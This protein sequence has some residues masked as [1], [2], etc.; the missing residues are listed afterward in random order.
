MQIP[1]NPPNEVERLQALN[2]YQILDSSPEPAFDEIAELAAFVMQVPVALVSLVDL[3][4]Q[5]FKARVGLQVSELP[6][7]V[8]F[9]G[10]VVGADTQLIVRDA[11]EDPRFVDNPLST[12][13]PQVRFYAGMPLRTSDGFVLGTLC[14]IDY[15]PRQPTDEQLGML[16]RLSR[17]VVHLLTN[18]RLRLQLADEN[19]QLREATGRLQSVFDIMDEGVVVQGITGEIVSNNIAATRILALSDDQLRGRTSI[20][21]RWQCVYEDGTPFPGAEHPSMQVLR[22]GARQT[23]VVMGVNIPNDAVRWISIN[24]TPSRVE[25]GAVHEVVTSFH[26]I[27]L[28]KAAAERLSQQQR[29]ATTGTLVAGIGHEINNPL[30]FVLGNLDLAIEE[31]RSLAGPSPSARLR[32][33]HELLH[34]ARVGADRIRRIVRGLRALSREEVALQPVDLAAVIETSLSMAQHEVRHKAAV[35]VSV[36]GLPSVLGDE[37]QLTQVLVNLLVNAGQAF[38]TAD[39]EKNLI[40]IHG[41]PTDASWLRL[42]VSDNGPGIP[43]DLTSRVFDPFFTTKAVSVGTGLGLA[44]SRGIVNGLGGHLLLQQPLLQQPLLQSPRE[45]GAV[46]HI[47]LRIADMDVEQAADA[48]APP[49]GLRGRVLVVDDDVSVL[50]TMRRA[51]A[52]EHDVVAMS[53]PREALALLRTEHSF[54]VIFCDLM[55]PHLTGQDLYELLRHERAQIVERIVFVTGGATSP[56]SRLFLDQLPNDVLAKPFTIAALLDTARRYLLRH[57]PGESL[58]AKPKPEAPTGLTQ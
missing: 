34:E 16:D 14:A 33:L 10:H 25:G 46:F 53:D 17:Q 18:R 22:T 51:L 44:V 9:C 4:R 15:R 47:D 5:W 32:E 7:D 20:D 2:N 30:A 54:D 19:Q 8:S 38:E 28:L 23:N 36:Q 12:G 43:G 58:P 26:D 50:S 42:S 31:L 57:A 1:S 56:S 13:D 41:A 45:T 21:P 29:L 48:V 24:S 11:L 27:T 49:Q 39:P 37:S 52:R 3:H 35:K 40:V 6:R 55:M